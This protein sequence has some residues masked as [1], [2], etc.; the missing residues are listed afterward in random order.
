MPVPIPLYLCKDMNQK[1]MNFVK[2][3][4]GLFLLFFMLLGTFAKAAG[5]DSLRTRWI[6]GKKFVLHKVTPKETWS[7]VSRRYQIELE[8]LQKANPGVA[9]LKIGQIIN[10]PASGTTPPPSVPAAPKSSSAPASPVS[11][12][13]KPAPQTVTSP[14]THTVQKGET[15]YRISKMY[16]MTVDELKSLNGLT[17]NEISL[18]QSLRVKSGAGVSAPVKET[19]APKVIETAVKTE[20]K[21][22]AETKPAVAAPAPEPA[23]EK[24][25]PAEKPKEMRKEVISEPVKEAVRTQEAAPAKTETKTVESAE[26]TEDKELPAVY[27]NPGVL[28]TSTIEKDPKSGAEIEK[29]TEVG[30]AA[31]LTEPDLNQSKFY[32]LHRTAPIGTIIKLTNRMNNNSVFVKVVGTLPDTGD[33]KSIIVK[34]TQAAAQRIGALD[35]KFTAELSYGIAR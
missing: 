32:A 8:D 12:P 25:V 35:Q 11:A 30:V 4:T 13:V 5:P 7:S 14:K 10:I 28:R 33:N 2:G 15:L 18:G 17:S 6:N 20:V 19:A 27:N 9:D 3:R 26:K 16:G 34:I 21:P 23:K 22:A 1:M 24:E 31:W 29:I